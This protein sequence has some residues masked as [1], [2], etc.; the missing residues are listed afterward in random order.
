MG[1]P[2]QH[3]RDRKDLRRADAFLS[4]CPHDA[5]PVRIP[6]RVPC[7]RSISFATLPVPRSAHFAWCWSHVR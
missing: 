1:F 4:S 2:V 3:L 7:S 5:A 6:Q